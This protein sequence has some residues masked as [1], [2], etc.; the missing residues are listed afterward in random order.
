[1]R[2]LTLTYLLVLGAL[3]FLPF[4]RGMDL[5]DRLNLHPFVTI[6]RALELG[7]RSLSFRL[8]LGNIAAFVPLGI[9]I[10][11]LARFRWWSG[12]AVLAAATVLSTGIEAGQLAISNYL[13]YAYRSTD[14]DDVILN[15]LGAILGYVVALSIGALVNIGDRLGDSRRHSA[16][17]R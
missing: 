16:N 8:M 9:L 17:D 1:L 3:V 15:V 4:G 10:P 13:G 6:E 2:W 14:V 11:L 7:P 5:G 12:L